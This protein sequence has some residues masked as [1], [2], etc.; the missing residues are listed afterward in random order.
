MFIQTGMFGGGA[1]LT[2]GLTGLNQTSFNPD[3]KQVYSQLGGT[4]SSVV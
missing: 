3:C 1:N 4:G 2:C